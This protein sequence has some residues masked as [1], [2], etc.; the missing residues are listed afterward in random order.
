MLSLPGNP[1]PCMVSRSEEGFT[2]RRLIDV[3]IGGSDGLPAFHQTSLRTDNHIRANWNRCFEILDS[4]P[5]AA[6]AWQEAVV[7][8][9]RVAGGESGR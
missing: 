3:D 9:K 1:G 5:V 2:S 4:V 8:R 6:A 7:C